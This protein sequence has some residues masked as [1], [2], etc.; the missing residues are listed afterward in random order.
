MRNEVF[1]ESEGGIATVIIANPGKRN[2]LTVDMWCQLA[3]VFLTLGQ[4]P[5]LRCVVVRG[6]GG[7]GFA[8]GAD[9]SEFESVRR[10]RAQVE[11]FHERIVLNAL[12]E[13]YQCACP[14]VALI[15]GACVGGGLEIAS[16]C[17]LRI[18]GRNAQ[19]GIPVNMLGFPLA[20]REMEWLYQLV[21]PAVVAELTL[22]GIILSAEEALTKGLLTQVVDDS[23]VVEAAYA[24]A[25]KIARGAPLAVRTNKFQLR[26]LM[27]GRPLTREERLDVYSFAETRDYAEGIRA[28]REKSTPRFTGS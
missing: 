3:D 27:S 22:E 24:A 1:M 11:E 23:A 6:A 25:R 4:D 19:L 15:Q 16:V 14:V 10:T 28:F 5:D 26:R 18:A 21:G 9:I 12:S 17:D 7:E 13:I 2:A 8:A 20:P